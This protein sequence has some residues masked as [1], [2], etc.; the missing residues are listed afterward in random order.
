MPGIRH[1]TPVGVAVVVVLVGM[2]IASI[3]VIADRWWAFRR[4]R[5]RSRASAESLRALLR[6]GRSREALAAKESDPQAHLARVLT[7]GLRE[8]ESL[9]RLDPDPDAAAL[10]TREAVRQATALSLEEMRRGLAALATI[11]STA[12]FVGL[13]GTTFGILTAFADI[14]RAGAGGFGVIAASIS[15]A[16]VTTALGLFVAIPAVAAYNTFLR[17]IESFGMELDR[18]GYEL[19]RHLRRAATTESR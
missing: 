18:H 19:V 8:W 9:C 16:L 1:F 2:S 15:E 7:T 6:D 4:A 5:R 3:A 12:P 17:R 13:F 14:A 10:A 11:G